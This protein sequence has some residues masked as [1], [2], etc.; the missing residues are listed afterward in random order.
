MKVAVTGGA[1]FIGSATVRQLRSDGYEVSILDCRSSES[2]V[3]SVDIRHKL[4]LTKALAT[5]D[6][7]IHLAGLV[8]TQELFHNPHDA[9]QTNVLGTIN[10][11]EECA[12]SDLRYVGITMPDAFPS[13]YTATRMAATRL[14]SAW[15]NAHGIPVSH[16][17]A[18]NVY[19]ARQRHG[20]GYPTKI[21]PTFATCAWRNKPI[22][23]WG[24]GTQTVDLVHVDD[25]ARLLV[26]ALQFG[27]DETFDGGTGHALSVNDVARIVISATGSRSCIEY[28]QMPPGV[29]KTKIAVTHTGWDL[30][31]A[32]LHP[33][34]DLDALIETIG[35]Y[36]PL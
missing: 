23:V 27:N 6:A 2:E 35:W 14:A 13:V 32:E 31:P 33:A 18:F 10:I 15:H 4:V 24:D 9:V 30:L 26:S 28:C 7:V 17:R 5:C 11:L 1:G 16:V 34:F 20:Y 36:K 21:I 19:G 12:R 29:I 22:P 3:H 25:V 8:G